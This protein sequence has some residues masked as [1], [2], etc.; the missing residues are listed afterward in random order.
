MLQ[1][2]YPD[3]FAD[4]LLKR[5]E[6]LRVPGSDPITFDSHQE[7]AMLA[8]AIAVSD[9]ERKFSVVHP[10]GSGKTVL[11][12]GIVQASQAAKKKLGEAAEGTKDL[13]LTVERSLIT[14][15]REHLEATLGEEVGQWGM[16][17]RNL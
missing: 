12:A 8:V 13:V 5:S 14:N 6:G 9:G 10:G 17:E 3:L 7:E 2:N 15:V 4:E 1:E 11:E 16:G